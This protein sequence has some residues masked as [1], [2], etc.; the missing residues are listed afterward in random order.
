[1]GNWVLVIISKLVS[2]QQHKLSFPPNY[3]SL[4]YSGRT[5]GLHIEHSR[6]RKQVT[7]AATFYS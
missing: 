3:K 6:N 1:M 4:T 5:V 2:P 7:A